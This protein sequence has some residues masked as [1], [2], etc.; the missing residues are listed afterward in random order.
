VNRLLSDKVRE[1]NRQ[2]EYRDERVSEL[3]AAHEIVK[4]E[5]ERHSA[6]V[7]SLRQRV[8]DCETRHKG[9][10]GAASHSEQQL[11]TLQAE[12][13]EAK[14]HILQLEAQIRLITSAVSDCLLVFHILSYIASTISKVWELA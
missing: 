12:Y 1:L 7:T 3:M 10:E 6:L 11:V 5:A 14:Q 13:R 9:L 8:A 4:Q 2:L